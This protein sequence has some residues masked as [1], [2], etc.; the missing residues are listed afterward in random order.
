M[1]TG[2]RYRRTSPM[3]R[4][5]SSPV[6]TF[7]IG[8]REDKKKIAPRDAGLRESFRLSSTSQSTACAP[9]DPRQQKAFMPHNPSTVCGGHWRTSLVRFSERCVLVYAGLAGRSEVDRT[10]GFCRSLFFQTFSSITPI[11][12]K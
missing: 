9:E 1:K 3:E 11:S 10:T 7:E 4:R 8:S 5:R 6:E 12:T 2:Y